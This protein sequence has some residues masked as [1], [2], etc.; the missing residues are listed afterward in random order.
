M[1]VT[2][3]DRLVGGPKSTLKPR[4]RVEPVGALEASARA[5]A[6]RRFLFFSRLA[7]PRISWPTGF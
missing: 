2:A 7:L 4:L 5:S 3:L 1:G 6:W